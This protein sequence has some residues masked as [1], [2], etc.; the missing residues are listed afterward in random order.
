MVGPDI[1]KLYISANKAYGPASAFKR[2][3]DAV[4]LR[5]LIALDLKFM[6]GCDGYWMFDDDETAA[7]AG[8]A[9]IEINTDHNVLQP[10]AAADDD[11]A[12]AA[13]P[14]SP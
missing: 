5:A 6:V 8:A 12:P 1:V 7:A 9:H 3:N 13:A 11:A 10:A 4:A 2:L 14:G